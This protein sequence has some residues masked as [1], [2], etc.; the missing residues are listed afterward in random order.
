MNTPKRDDAGAGALFDLTVIDAGHYIAGPYA[1]S[2]LA[3]LGAEVIKVERPQ[4]GD[5]ARRLGPFPENI[6]HL[7]KSGLFSYLNLGK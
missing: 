7:E 3:G 5:G 1:A 6:P 2:L 4:V